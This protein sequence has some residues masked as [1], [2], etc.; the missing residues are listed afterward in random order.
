VIGVEKLKQE[1]AVNDSIFQFDGDII[2]VRGDDMRDG[3]HTP[4]QP[5]KTAFETAG[6]WAGVTSVTAEAEPSQW[7]HHKDHDSVMYMLNGE[8]R[9][10]WGDDGEKSFTL[11]PGDF[12]FFRRGTIHRAQVLESDGL[13]NFVVV[14]IGD[15]ETVENV[16]GP[17]PNVLVSSSSV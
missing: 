5:R 14:R 12:A 2:Y 9:V 15:G 4:G 17:G 6:L 13:C 3:P 1:Q 8:I 11:K 7:H 16:D 10:D